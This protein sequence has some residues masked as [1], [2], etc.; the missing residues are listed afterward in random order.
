MERV[1]VRS[2]PRPVFA[3]LSAR[4]DA[5]R[6][7]ISWGPRLR[8][9]ACR[10]GDSGNPRFEVP[11]SQVSSSGFEDARLRLACANLP[12]PGVICEGR[13][14]LSSSV[15]VEYHLRGNKSDGNARESLARLSSATICQCNFRLLSH[16]HSCHAFMLGQ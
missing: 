16:L 5:S 6:A 3:K 2:Q 7:G 15:C 9:A 13:F 10:A 12:F 11:G 14:F 1:A 4:G 8:I